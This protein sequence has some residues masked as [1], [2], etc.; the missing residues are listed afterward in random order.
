[1]DPDD[2]VK[3]FLPAIAMFQDPPAWTTA[4]EA[5][6]DW[7][8]LQRAKALRQQKAQFEEEKAQVEVEVSK[9]ESSQSKPDLTEYPLAV[10][11]AGLAPSSHHSRR[12]SLHFG[13]VALLVV[14]LLLLSATTTTS[15]SS[16]FRP[17]EKEPSGSQLFLPST[18][19]QTRKIFSLV[20]TLAAVDNEN[21]S[22]PVSKT[23][24]SADTDMKPT[25]VK[26]LPSIVEASGFMLNLEFTSTLTDSYYALGSYFA[27][28]S[29][30]VWSFFRVQLVKL[31]GVWDEKYDAVGSFVADEHKPEHVWSMLHRQLMKVPAVVR[32]VVPLS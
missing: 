20:P 13:F 30:H 28:K 1:M 3:A 21:C 18:K 19:R 31:R 27:D 11:A 25:T 26:V 6:S 9:P 8:L 23:N 32:G 24:K 14:C 5:P 29:Q 15:F 2:K 10:A 4:A 22:A 17:A 12:S 7:A 16:L